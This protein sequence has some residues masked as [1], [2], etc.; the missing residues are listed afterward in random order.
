MGPSASVVRVTVGD[1]DFFFSNDLRIEPDDESL[2]MRLRFGSD[3]DFIG[4]FRND[5]GMVGCVGG[6]NF[7]GNKNWRI[8]KAC[9]CGLCVGY[10]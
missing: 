1:F 4:R 10:R 2:R 7:G 3:S 6:R 8:A 5:F 9:Y